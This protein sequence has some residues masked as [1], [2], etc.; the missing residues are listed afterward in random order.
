MP[1]RTERAMIAD[2]MVFMAVLLSVVRRRNSGCSV[3]AALLLPEPLGVEL[4]RVRDRRDCDGEHRHCDKGRNNRLH[5][6]Q[7]SAV[8]RRPFA[9]FC[10]CRTCVSAARAPD[11]ARFASARRS[12]RAC[13]INGDHLHFGRDREVIFR[14]VASLGCDVEGA[15]CSRPHPWVAPARKGKAW[16]HFACPWLR[17]GTAPCRSRAGDARVLNSQPY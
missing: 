6:L 7:S 2:A 17:S 15:C 9:L 1:A 12:P 10:L 16:Q 14:L 3:A 5:D 13:V 8:S 11:M 4:G